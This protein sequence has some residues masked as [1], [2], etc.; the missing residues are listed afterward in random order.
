MVLGIAV[1]MVRLGGGC[2]NCNRS[3]DNRELL[4]EVRVNREEA[5]RADMRLNQQRRGGGDAAVD[6]GITDQR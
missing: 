6:H 1:A 2:R 4:R 3:C 5:S